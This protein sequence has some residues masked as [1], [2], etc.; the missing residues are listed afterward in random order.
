MIG[1]GCA[2]GY[3]TSEETREI[4][5][6]GLK[7][8]A[9]D[10]KRV[11]V[12]IPDGTRTMPM[13]QMFALFEEWLSPRVGALD[14]LV[15]LGTHPPM[16]DAQLSRLVGQAVVHGQAGRSHIYNHEWEDPANFAHIGTIPAGEINRITGGLMS[17]EIP[18]KLNKLILAYDQLLIC[19][20]VFPHEVVGFSGG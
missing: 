2:E 14:Y 20:P 7:T 4:V 10:G 17:Q 6:A 18:V 3:L 5:R 11:L 13:P 9:V 12:I 15:A 8:L 19:G 16:T 1:K